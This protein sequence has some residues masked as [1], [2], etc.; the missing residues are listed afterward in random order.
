[1]TYNLIM[2]IKR[3]KDDLKNYKSLNFL[4]TSEISFIFHQLHISSIY[5]FPILSN[6][7]SGSAKGF[8]KFA[9]KFLT[10][11]FCF[12]NLVDA[13]IFA[14]NFALKLKMRIFCFKIFLQN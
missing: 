11:N 9:K 8:S 6:F 1:M 13:I 14:S 5:F 3:Y 2:S 4:H 7:L 10:L 12:H